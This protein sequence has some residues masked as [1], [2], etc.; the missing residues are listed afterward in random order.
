[1]TSVIVDDVEVARARVAE[2]ESVVL[3]LEAGAPT[4]GEIRQGP[5]RLA[6]I[7]GS[8][9]DPEVRRAAE[10]MARELF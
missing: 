8:P 2:G 4:L 1:M 3:I 7:V 5:G 9:S 6:V 10:A